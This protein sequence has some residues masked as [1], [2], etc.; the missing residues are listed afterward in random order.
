MLHRRSANTMLNEE[1]GNTDFVTKTVTPISEEMTEILISY[2]FEYKYNSFPQDIAAFIDVQYEEKLPLITI[3]LVTPDDRELKIDSFIPNKKSDVYYFTRQEILRRK[4]KT[5]FPVNA[6]LSDPNSETLTP[7]KGT[8]NLQIKAFVFEDDSDMEAELV[9]YGQVY[10]I[11]GT[12]GKRRDIMIPLLWGMPIALSFGI[13]AAVGTSF[14]SMLIAA[15]STW[16]GGWIDNLTQRIT[17]IN[18][19]LPFL[20]VSIMIYV[21]Y[22]KSFWTIL[23][24]SVIL[25][26]FGNEIKNYR[27]IFLQIMEEKYIEAARSYGA[28]DWRIIT[29]YLIPRIMPIMIPKLVILVPSYVFL[30]ATLTLLGI[31]DPVM[32]TWGK[33][34]VEGFS[35]DIYRGVYHLFLEPLALLLLVG[36]AFVLLGISLERIFQPRLR[37]R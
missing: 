4:Y 29:R 36:F 7:L 13:L 5:E 21:L 35:S 14:S 27:S 10:G 12:D 3:T 22:S 37:E 8:Y 1:I 2:T 20:P 6:I 9:V 11:A 26:I 16:F 33:L 15:L 24:V 17:E 28:K 25:N 23:G 19:I 34:L 18:L 30:E 32:P 31:S